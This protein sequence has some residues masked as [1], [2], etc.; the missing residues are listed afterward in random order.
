MMQQ[1]LPDIGDVIRISA[2][3]QDGELLPRTPST[4]HYG[5]N[6]VV[7]P[8]EYEAYVICGG[9]LRRGFVLSIRD[10]PQRV[11]GFGLFVVP[12]P[13]DVT[14][15]TRDEA[16]FAFYTRVTQEGF[17]PRRVDIVHIGRAAPGSYPTDRTFVG[18]RVL[19]ARAS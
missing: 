8:S 1:A 17:E 6:L 15:T 16:T 13:I 2:Q 3:P 12:C 4:Y 19:L 14:K 5:P 10:D 7:E 9:G 11:V 18:S